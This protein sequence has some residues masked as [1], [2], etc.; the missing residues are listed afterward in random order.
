M[1]SLVNPTNTPAPTVVWNDWDW[2]TPDPEKVLT[3]L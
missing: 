3:G 1:N 2:I